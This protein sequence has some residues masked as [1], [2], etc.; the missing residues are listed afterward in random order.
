MYQNLSSLPPLEPSF[1]S[2]DL[3]E[4][5]KRQWEPSKSGY[6][7]WAVGRLLVKGEAMDKVESSTL[8][9]GSGEDLRQ[10]LHSVDVAK[11]KLN[12]LVGQQQHAQDHDERVV[13][14]DDRME[15]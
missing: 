8:E 2:V 10:A 5:G 6:L 15:E 13:G 3:T 9:I 12:A 1:G 4:P 14:D 11:G 7:N